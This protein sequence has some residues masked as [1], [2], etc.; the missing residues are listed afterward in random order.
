M[1]VPHITLQ[2]SA[3]HLKDTT[4]LSHLQ[5]ALNSPV[6]AYCEPCNSLTVDQHDEFALNEA[7]PCQYCGEDCSEATPERIESALAVLR[8][9]LK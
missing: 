8:E 3:E 5:N 9:D 4:L 1:S 6:I 2:L 7:M